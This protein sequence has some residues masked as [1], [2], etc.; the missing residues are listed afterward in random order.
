MFKLSVTSVL[1][2]CLM[3]QVFA[4]DTDTLSLSLPTNGKEVQTPPLEAYREF[5]VTLRSPFDLRLLWHEGKPSVYALLFDGHAMP[6]RARITE[7]DYH[8]DMHELTFAFT[9]KGDPLVVRLAKDLSA[10][11]R[12]AKL[13]IS[14]VPDPPPSSPKTPA[15]QAPPPLPV[16]PRESTTGD[17]VL[18]RAVFSLPTTGSPIKTALPLQLH[19]SYDIRLKAP[20]NLG[21][22]C[23]T[24]QWELFGLQ[25]NDSLRQRTS[26]PACQ[27]ARD[28]EEIVVPYIG[29]GVPLLLQMAKDVSDVLPEVTVEISPTPE[30]APAPLSRL[31]SPVLW[32]AT[33]VGV[34][35]CWRLWAAVRRARRR[36][37]PVWVDE[38]SPRLAL[39]PGHVELDE[40]REELARAR[41]DAQQARREAAYAKQQTTH[42]RQE[43]DDVRRRAAVLSHWAEL[44]SNFLRPDYQQHY[45]ATHLRRVLDK[46][47]DAW[48]KEARDVRDDEPLRSLL[49]QE[50]PQVLQVLEARLEVIRIAERLEVEPSRKPKLTPEEH[51]ERIERFRQRLTRRI[52]V[53]AQDFMAKH[54]RKLTLEQEFAQELEGYDLDEDER[55]RLMN[56]FRDELTRLTEGEEEQNETY[57]TAKP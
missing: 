1:L 51:Q 5:R 34:V 22:L 28:V 33:G 14:R 45:A 44:E 35:V 39:P 26:I 31:S 10:T 27:E 55:E 13:E 41:R 21:L 42:L 40:A 18:E 16:A 17:R 2:L 30:P 47:K 36:D 49:E 23:D 43:Q 19:R 37:A 15:A 46:D 32:V 50:Y 6:D 48:F 4:K 8:H 52:D 9:G 56:A 38:P 3:G 12:H 25:L 53:K 11:I 24:P 7:W 54:M 29:R 57:K 20:H